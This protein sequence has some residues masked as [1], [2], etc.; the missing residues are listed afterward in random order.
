MIPLILG[1]VAFFTVHLIPTSPEMRKGLVD[2]FGEGAYKLA[3]SIASILALAV[4][5]LGYYKLQVNPGKNPVLWQPPMALRHV[6]LGLMLPAMWL[7][8]AAYVPSK[9]RTMAKHPMLAAVKVWALAHLLA[10]GDIGSIVLF[11]S[12]LVWAVFDR[13]SVKR[14]GGGHGPLGTKQGTVTG[15]AIVILGGTG[16]YL[17]MLYYGHRLLIGVPVLS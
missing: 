5:V 17:F 1:L 13:I 14:R 10:N 11:G 8:V 7:L 15:D 6:A 12:F 4:I 16:L 9:L 2:R 3:F